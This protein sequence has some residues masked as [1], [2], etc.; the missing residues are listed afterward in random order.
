MCIAL[1]F[2]FYLNC[3]DFRMERKTFSCYDNFVI[4]NS[5]GAPTHGP[6]GN[7]LTHLASLIP[8]ALRRAQTLQR[9]VNESPTADHSSEGNNVDVSLCSK[10]LHDIKDTEQCPTDLTETNDICLKDD[11]EDTEFSEITLIGFS[12][13]CV[14]LNQ[15]ITELHAVAIGIK[16]TKLLDNFIRKVS[17]FICLCSV[18]VLSIFT[19]NNI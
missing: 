9:S 7:A 15:I 18:S 17:H 11:P 6:E 4:S 19:F 14:V 12:K 2:F 10:S 16:Q 3:F 13:G 5:V 1:K 8:K